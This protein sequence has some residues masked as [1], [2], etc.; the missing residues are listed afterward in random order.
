MDKSTQKRGRQQ[1]CSFCGKGQGQVKHLIAGPDAYAGT[2]VY[3]CDECAV[4]V[5]GGPWC[6]FKNPKTGKEIIIKDSIADAFLQQ[7]LLRRRQ[8][9]RASCRERV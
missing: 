2:P 9:G 5:D 1:V 4:E 7:I 6:A 3:I 8:I